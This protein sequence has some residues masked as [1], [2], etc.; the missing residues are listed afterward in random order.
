MITRM[1]KCGAF[2]KAGRDLAILFLSMSVLAACDTSRFLN[3][4]APSRLPA[5]ELE[6]PSNAPLLVDGA[7]EDFGCAFASVVL[8]EAIVSDEFSD[9]Q[10]GAA[11]WPYD[12]RDANTQPS[13]IYGTSGCDSNQNPGVYRPLSTARFSAD[14]ALKLLQGWTDAEVPK[15]DSLIA[16]AALYS[17]YSYTWLG[18]T[19]CNAAIDEGPEIGQQDLFALAEDKFN[20]A[21]QEG[22][23]AGL[24]DLVNAAYVGRARVRL[25]QGDMSG[26]ISDAQQVP[27]GFVYNADYSSANNR[28]YNRVFASNVQYRMYSVEDQDRALMTAGV[29]DPRT[30]AQDSHQAGAD[31]SDVWVQTKYTSFS[32]PIPIAKYEE[33]Q[34]ILAEAEGG[35]AAVAIIN[36]LRDEVGLPHFQSTDP[37]AIMNQ[38]IDE[39]RKVLFVEGQRQYDIERFNL[40]QVPAPGTAYP[41]KGGTYGNTTCFPLPNVERFNNPNIP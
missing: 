27:A 21:I 23:T 36:G 29:V 6:S 37:Q 5:A 19:M 7:V 14:N 41:V 15:R 17:A 32:S 39:R 34:L 38:V 24:T 3:V 18:M 20:L 16:V 11:A 12:R 33:A 2:G 1:K 26:A 31:G 10:L 22:G 30:V 28:R 13:G 40:P 8:V 4:T 35:Q 25:F 9:A